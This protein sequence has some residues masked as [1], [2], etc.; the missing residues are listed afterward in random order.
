MT[1]ID[2]LLMADLVGTINR[3]P[4][5]LRIHGFDGSR[6]FSQYVDNRIISQIIGTVWGNAKSRSESLPKWGIMAGM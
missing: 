6:D 3:Q 5:G 1:W 2:A 4:S